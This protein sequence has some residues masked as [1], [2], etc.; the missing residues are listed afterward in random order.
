MKKY[1]ENG[2]LILTAIFYP[3]VMAVGFVLWVISAIF[4][5]VASLFKIKKI[6]V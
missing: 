5:E 1:T 4:T 2:L 3:F 6:D